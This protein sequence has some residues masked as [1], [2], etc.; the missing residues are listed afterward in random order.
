MAT[1]PQRVAIVGSGVAGLVAAYVAS[2]TCE[3]ALYEADDRLGGHADTHVVPDAA[4]GRDLL[5]DTGFIVHNRQT[6]PVLMRLFGELGVPTQESDMSMSVADDETDIEWAGALGVAGLFPRPRLLAHRRHLRMLTEIPRFHRRA[7]ALLRDAADSSITVRDFLDEGGFSDH[8]R[9]HFMAPLVAA[10]WSCDHDRALDYP[11]AYLFQFL[12]HHGMLRVFGSP[13]WRTVT[14]GSRT[15]V[16]RVAAAITATGGKIHLGEPVTGVVE[17]AESITVHTA[18]GSETYDA[19]IIATHPAQALRA[20]GSPSD[21]QREILGA[22]DY[23]PNT[24]TLHTDASLMPRA[25]RAWAS[26]NVR[27]RS[28]NDDHVLVTYDLTRLQRL[29]TKQHYLVTLGG[30]DLIDPSTV[31]A[32]REYEHPLYTPVS[33]AARGRLAEI[34][35]ERIG[36]AGAYH[37]W[38]FHEDGALSGL[39]AAERL[40]LHWPEALPARAVY[41]TTLTHQRRTPVRHGFKLKSRFWC[42]DLDDSAALSPRRGWLRGTFEGRDHFTGQHA[43]IREGLDDFLAENGIDV[44]GGRAVMAAQP[45]SLGHCFNPISVH[46]AWAGLDTAGPPDATVV[47]VHNTYGDRTAYLLDPDEHGMAEVPKQM[48]VSPFHGVDGRYVVHV[49]PPDASRGRLGIGVTLH[50]DG[51]ANGG[52][53]FDAGLVGRVAKREPAIAL[54]GL[55]GAFLI[56]LHGVYLWL[57]RLPIQKRR[58]HDG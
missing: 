53:R 54:A 10:V 3:V 28:D 33:V 25:S 43:S 55:R 34:N 4:S 14:G 24:A 38:G 47:E 37:G 42:V 51:D 50:P 39:R 44:R 36:F 32:R 46:W 6:Y 8:F 57:R 23:V 30:T 49:P 2:R 31:I 40:G 26:W 27:R 35:T 45:R 56:R 7:R 20:L 13:P 21:V 16:E 22:L 17:T 58:P 41:S 48:Y 52:T 9:Q 18:E 1:S 29:A 19:V 12:S 15:Y 5:I 11:A